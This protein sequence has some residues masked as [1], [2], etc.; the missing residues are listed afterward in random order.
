[1][2]AN[3]SSAPHPVLANSRQTHVDQPGTI[4]V[5]HSHE[6]FPKGIREVTIAHANMQYRLRIT[7]QG[8]LI[9]TK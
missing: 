1:M 2:Q 3:M 5:L 9:L 6:L 8:K 7:A 4:P